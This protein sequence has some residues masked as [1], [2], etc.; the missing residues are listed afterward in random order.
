MLL[1]ALA[2]GLPAR[3]AEGRLKATVFRYE[4]LPVKVNGQ[5]KGRAV[6]DTATHT[7]FGVEV[8][9][10]ELAPGQSPHPPHHHVHEEMMMLQRGTLEANLAGKLTMMTPGSV[11]FVESGIEHGIRNPGTEPCQY[12]VI[13]LGNPK[14]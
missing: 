7:G 13:A 2:A 5:N 11:L 12:F 6:L 1:P 4:D 14:G 3:A 9:I 10:T 8:H